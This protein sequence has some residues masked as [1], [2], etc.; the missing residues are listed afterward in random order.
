MDEDIETD[1]TAEEVEN[2]M[3]V[4][5]VVER[6]EIDEILDCI[7]QVENEGKVEMFVIHNDNDV[8]END[9]TV[10]IDELDEYLILALDVLEIEDAEL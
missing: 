4:I 1:E 8:L 10:I 5:C 9:E 3:D 6:D 2:E 7:E